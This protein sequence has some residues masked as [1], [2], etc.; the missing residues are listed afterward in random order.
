MDSRERLKIM[1]YNQQA[2]FFTMTSRATFPA[3]SAD[4]DRWSV[5]T[6]FTRWLAQA[7]ELS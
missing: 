3:S 7:R 6:L 4:N 1:L 2:V 5:E